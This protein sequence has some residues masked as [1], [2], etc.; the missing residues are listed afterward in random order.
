MKTP[1]TLSQTARGPNRRQV[2]GTPLAASVLPVTAWAQAETRV[3]TI[4]REGAFVS[5]DPVKGFEDVSLEQIDMAYNR[6]VRYAWLERPYRVEPDLLASLPEA[7][8][9]G[10]TYSFTLRK[11]IRFHDNA[12]FPGGKGRELT[13]D[14]VLFSLKRYADFHL[15]QTSWFLLDGMVAGLNELRAATQA[16][17]T[18]RDLDRLSISGFQRLDAHRFTLRLTRPN[19]QFVSRLA[20]GP[21][22]I[23]PVEAVRH[24][25]E[26]FGVNPV[27][28]GAFMLKDMDRKGTIRWVRN[29]NYHGVYPSRGESGDREAGLLE[30]AGRKQPFLD[31]VE[32]TLMEESQP[33]ML[34]MLRGELDWITLDRANADKMV[35]GVG[36]QL[37]LAPEYRDK[38]S[39]SVNTPMSVR[40]VFINMKDPVLGRN[41]LLRQ[42]LARLFDVAG[43]VA[44]LMGGRGRPLGSIVPYDL[45]GSER[46]TGAAPLAYDPAGAKRL[47]A[48]AGFPDG[49]GLPELTMR[50]GFSGIEWRNRFDFYQSKLA[51]AGVR[52]KPLFTDHPTFV[53][54]TEAS[55]FQM[56]MYGWIADYPDAENFYQLMFSKNAAPGPNLSSFQNDA[57]DAAYEASRYLAPSPQRLVYQRKMSEILREEVPI[58]PL[59][60]AFSVV[61]KQA[62]V[63][64]LKRH[65]LM[66][67]VEYLDID[68]VRKR[69]GV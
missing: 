6:L 31:T 46:D 22:S 33:R 13:S 23:V 9:D 16:A 40:H 53:K 7:S 27:G 44:Q 18:A 58:I 26:K 52:L 45:P 41:K 67:G 30:A 10:L 66:D 42:A 14:D 54:A 38:F 20:V 1:D 49:K 8:A 19:A 60:S 24:H 39:I 2:I 12:C 61:L 5:M 17:G 21:L 57:Y 35:R 11:G 47:L 62:W 3:M 29:P 64:N 28:T 43:D 68:P 25:G 48:Q 65:A 55:N 50:W 51:E 32:M 56:A 4:A 69:K 34:K 36:G 63:K 59:H 37:S 15:N